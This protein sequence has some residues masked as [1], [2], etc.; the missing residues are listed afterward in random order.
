MTFLGQSLA[1]VAMPCRMMTD[2]ASSN[3]MDHSTMHGM[4]HS[5]EM[6]HSMIQDV[7]CMD[8]SDNPV[9]QLHDCCKTL[10]HCAS[11]T[12]PALNYSFSIGIEADT[13][14]FSVQYFLK[15]PQKLVSSLYRPPIFS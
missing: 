3:H 5:S 8:Q 10:G 7:S 15:I 1:V 13:N 9:N 12:L 4:N 2:Q 11:C 6:N 14:Q